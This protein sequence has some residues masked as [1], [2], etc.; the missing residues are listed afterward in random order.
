MNTLTIND[1]TLGEGLP[2][3]IVPLIAATKNQLIS[4]AKEVCQSNCDLIEWRIDFFEDVK[5][6]KIVANVS[7]TLRK[8]IDKPLL[9]TFR[10]HKEGGEL[11][12]SNDA[13][14]ELYRV[15]INE[16]AADLI[17]LELFMPA[18]NIKK[19]INLAHKKNI[20]VILCNHDF[21]STP[22]KEEIISRLRQ[23]QDKGADICKIAVMPNTRKDVLTLLDATRDMF[24]N[25]AKCPLITMSMGDLGMISRIAGNTF[26][27]VATFGSTRTASAPGQIPVTEL[28][29]LLQT[30]AL[31]TEKSDI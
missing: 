21:D 13:Y 9:I 28:R 27:S 19:T 1:V 2:K 7:H 10:T 18:E 29:K 3:I 4:D 12:L 20:K 31:P 11:E 25:Y 6:P 24:E 23:M 14:F 8:I 17:D 5:Q 22:S 26:G 15:L 16:E 30:L